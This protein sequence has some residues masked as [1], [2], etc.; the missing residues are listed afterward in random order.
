MDRLPRTCQTSVVFA[1]DYSVQELNLNRWLISASDPLPVTIKCGN[2]D[3]V[4]Q[5]ISNNSILRL[6][7]ECTSF[8]GSTRIRAQKLV[9][10]YENITYSNHPV[11]IPFQCCDRFPDKIHLPDLK[12]LKLNKL[13]VEDLNI[14]HHK[15]NQYSDELDKLIQQPFIHKHISWFTV[16]TITV[17][18]A[19]IL[20]YVFCK[21]RRNR[22]IRIGIT[23]NSNDHPP[24][25]PRYQQRTAISGH[26]RNLL[27]R[28]RPS[29]HL[30]EPVEEEESLELNPANKQQV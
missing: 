3:I 13:D 29:I 9:E 10:A 20:L 17:I 11:T 5:I 7:P 28:R 23:T 19:L 12:P 16:L 15:L 25:A 21:C 22:K 2:R 27:P 4:T 1:K 30:G 26:L 14:A 24:D 18:V 6:Q 8:I